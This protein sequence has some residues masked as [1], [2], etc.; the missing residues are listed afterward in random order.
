MKIK[1]KK[2]IARSIIEGL[3]RLE[4]FT[5]PLD[6]CEQSYHKAQIEIVLEHLRKMES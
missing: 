2:E 4:D 6:K 3:D 5:H 1:N